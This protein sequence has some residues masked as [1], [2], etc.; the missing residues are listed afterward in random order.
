MYVWRTGRFGDP[1]TQL[2]GHTAALHDLAWAPDG[3]RLVSTSGDGYARIWH[4]PEAREIDHVLVGEAFRVRWSPDGR[5]FATGSRDGVVRVWDAETCGLAQELRHEEAIHAMDWS[6]DG[7]R[8]LVGGEYGAVVLW[9]VGLTHLQR[10][11]DELAR[12]LLTDDQ[13]RR[14]VADWPSETPN[15]VDP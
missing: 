2:A 1:P 13:I 15:A 8:I 10:E 14:L 9:R 7:E 6:P 12:S 3:A 11:L 4:V 5:F